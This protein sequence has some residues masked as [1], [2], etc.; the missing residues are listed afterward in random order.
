MLRRLVKQNKFLILSEIGRQSIE[1]P[2]YTKHL[3][4][5]GAIVHIG[6]PFKLNQL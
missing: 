1:I 6:L 4:D 3:I 5:V 2:Y